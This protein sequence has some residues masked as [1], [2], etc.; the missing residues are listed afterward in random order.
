MIQ[1][2]VTKIYLNPIKTAA[3]A[4]FLGYLSPFSISFRILC[5]TTEWRKIFSQKLGHLR[6]DV[7]FMSSVPK[8]F[9]LTIIMRTDKF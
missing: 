1:S 4:K 5:D 6:D 2:Y 8:V 7:I 3:E 9:V